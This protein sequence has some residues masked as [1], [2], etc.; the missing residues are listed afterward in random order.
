MI[1]RLKKDNSVLIGADMG[2]GKTLVAVEMI[3]HLPPAPRVLYIA[4]NNTHNQVIETVAEQFP[5]LEGSP[6]LRK[7]GTPRADPES[8]QQILAKKPG[9]YVIGWEAMH[10]VVPRDIRLKHTAKGKKDPDVT[11]KA[12]TECMKTGLV[13]PWNKA[14]TWDMVVLDESHRVQNPHSLNKKIV[15]QIKS[16]YRVAM[17]GT[18]SGNKPE[19][20]WSTLNWLWPDEYP[21]FTRWKDFYMEFEERV[22]GRG[23]TVRTI[24]GEAAPG[25]TWLDIP[26]AIRV[27][28]EDI[29]VHLPDVIERRVYVPM[30]T[31]QRKVYDDFEKQAMAWIDEQPYAA[32]L[33]IEK[34]IR[35]RQASLGPLKVIKKTKRKEL[36][37]DQGDVHKDLVTVLDD[38]GKEYTGRAVKVLDA[39]G[40]SSLVLFEYEE[41]QFEFQEKAEHHKVQAIREIIADLPP[42]AP[43]LVFT[44]SARWAHLAHGLLSKAKLGEVRAW[45]GELNQSQRDEL[46]LAFG[47]SVRIL[48]AV[49]PAVAEGIDGWQNVCRYEIWASKAE[50]ALL[51]EQAKARL[52]RPGQKS[53]VQRWLIHSENSIDDGVEE[54]LNIRGRRLMTMYR[55]DLK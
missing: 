6:Y 18:P 16:I 50:N 21:S 17:S 23:M 30:T 35:L 2:T 49:I 47:K 38:E 1:R 5:S 54:R 13:P 41:D 55:D 22:I 48:I 27:R 45:T 42:G 51:N 40:Y 39:L 43:V 14:G 3:R 46:K 37:I 32:P 8:W 24:V 25:A 11:V 34:R 26:N 36:W 10:G 28:L 52:H 4:P 44:H 7:V 31:E 53:P 9:V 33:P 12:I 20:L 15:K 19:G 29:G